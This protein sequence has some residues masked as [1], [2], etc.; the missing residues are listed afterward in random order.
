MGVSIERARLSDQAR[1]LAVLEERGRIA[2]ELHDS[3]TQTL[4]SLGL[5]SEAAL[6]LIPKDPARAAKHVES[7]NELAKDALSE[8]REMIDEMRPPL[9]DDEGLGAAI[10]R[11]SE[12]LTL[13]ALVKIEG[14]HRPSP[15]V[16]LALYWIAREALQNISRHA[17]AG[18]V[19][20]SLYELHES[21]T[22]LVVRDDGVGFDPSDSRAGGSGL[23]SMRARAEECGCSISIRSEPGHGARVHVRIPTR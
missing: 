19:E 8:L 14:E 2:R 15:E 16:E 22:V 20:V 17:S 23:S 6:K 18:H 21:G 9:L 7:V 10:Q 12:R 5:T 3:V 1:R 11:I 4:F 13:P